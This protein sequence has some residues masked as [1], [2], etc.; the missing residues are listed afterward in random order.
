MIWRAPLIVLAF[1]GSARAGDISGI[2]RVVDG[3]TLVIGDTRIRLEGID[4]FSADYCA[5]VKGLGATE[6]L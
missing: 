4:A 6:R 3:D 5:T 1:V 2:P